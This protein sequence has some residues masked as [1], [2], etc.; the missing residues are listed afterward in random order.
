MA[1]K[2]KDSDLSTMADLTLREQMD[3]TLRVAKGQTIADLPIDPINL[4]GGAEKI[5]AVKD[6]ESGIE[7]ITNPGSSDA[8]TGP[9]PASSTDNAVVRWDGATGRILQDSATILDDSDNI[10]IPGTITAGSGSEAITNVAGKTLHAAIEQN[11]ATDE[12]F[13]G[14]NNSKAFNY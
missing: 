12:Q 11:G 9:D 6:D 14:W 3:R 8:V 10:T 7:L 2:E 5:L 1:V 13:L 4:V